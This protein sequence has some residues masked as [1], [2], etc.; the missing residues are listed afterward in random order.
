MLS[1]ATY[2]EWAKPFSEGSHFQGDWSVGSKML[3][4]GPS[5]DGKISGM[6]SRIH[7]N[8]EHEFVSI[9]HL[10]FVA[11]G[12]EDTTSENVNGWAGA[13]ENYTFTEANGSTEVQVD[14][15]VID[16]YREMFEGMWPKA[17]EKL[18]E[19]AERS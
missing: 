11:D 3:F 6:V 17:L 16:E 1:D 5:E 14:I 2:R 12:I 10:G 19:I 18:K 13:Y 8:R 15:D 4:L 7:E 9:E